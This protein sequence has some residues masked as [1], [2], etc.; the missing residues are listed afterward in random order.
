MRY[1][2]PLDTDLLHYV[3]KNFKKIITIEDGAINGGLGS[4]V[5][6]F[7]V[8]NGYTATIKRLGIPDRF[9]DQGTIEELRTE[10]GINSESLLVEIRK[11]VSR[12]ILSRVI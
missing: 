5:A 1:L 2:K 7:M 9:I 11:M 6:E 4:A 12:K 8:D 3:F 10:C